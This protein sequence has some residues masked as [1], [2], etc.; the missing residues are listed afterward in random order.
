MTFY[1][2]L[3][4]VWLF[5]CFCPTFSCCAF[6]GIRLAIR[7]LLNNHIHQCLMG[8]LFLPVILVVI[9]KATNGFALRVA[10]QNPSHPAT[11]HSVGETLD[12]TELLGEIL[13][14]IGELLLFSGLIEIGESYGPVGARGLLPGTWEWG[15]GNALQHCLCPTSC[16]NTFLIADNWSEYKPNQEQMHTPKSREDVLAVSLFPLG[17][18]SLRGLVQP[19][20]VWGGV[21]RQPLPHADSGLPTQMWKPC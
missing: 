13:Q 18:G 6:G 16:C 5:T 10:Q 4:G 11:H 3:I 12:T 17:E 9:L 7:F 1:W 15:A 20:V 14:Q 21:E 2:Q 19:R 8:F